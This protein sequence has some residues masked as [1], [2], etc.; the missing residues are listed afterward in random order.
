[1][2]PIQFTKHRSIMLFLIGL[3]AIAISV[4]VWPSKVE[5]IILSIIFLSILISIGFSISRHFVSYRNG[6]IGLLAFAVRSTLDILGILITLVIAVGLAGQIGA[7]FGQAVNNAVEPAWPGKG[8]IAGLLAG[9]VAGTRHWADC[10]FMGAPDLGETGF[11]KISLEV[12]FRFRFFHRGISKGLQPAW[13][14]SLRIPRS[15]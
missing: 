14:C 9:L 11:D 10:R 8:A 6:Q 12:L 5:T 3:A 15:F 2:R 13:E 1:M 7:P 4:L